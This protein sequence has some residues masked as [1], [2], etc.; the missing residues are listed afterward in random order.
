MTFLVSSPGATFA[1]FEAQFGQPGV[2]DKYVWPHVE[3]V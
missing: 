3:Q 2:D 1:D